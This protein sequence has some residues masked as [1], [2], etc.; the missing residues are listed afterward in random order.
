MRNILTKLMVSRRLKKALAPTPE[1]L[2][3]SEERFLALM[4]NGYVRHSRAAAYVGRTATATSVI[5]ALLVGTSAYANYQNVGVG[6]PLYPLKRSYEQVE[7]AVAPASSAPALHVRFATRRLAEIEDERT[8]NPVSPALPALTRD[9]HTE[10]ELS[11]RGVSTIADNEKVALVATPAADTATSTGEVTS[12]PFRGFA[13]RESHAPSPAAT[14]NRD[15][16]ENDSVSPTDGSEASS[17]TPTSP[18]LPT[19]VIEAQPTSTEGRHQE[20]KRSFWPSWPTSKLEPLCTS[21]SKL[22]DNESLESQSFADENPE[23][24]SRLQSDCSTKGTQLK[25][26]VKQTET[27]GQNGTSQGDRTRTRDA[28][29]D[30]GN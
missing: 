4:P 7:L 14:P 20:E 12:T 13:P 5:A 15:R 10:L 21:L 3:K 18:V 16:H 23:A 17:S 9:F 27:S 6:S 25:V 29:E 30:S 24:V 19:A 26:E 2:A 8:A 11:V 22:I 28:H 1:F